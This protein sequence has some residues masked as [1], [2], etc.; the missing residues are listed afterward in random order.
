MTSSDTTEQEQTTS[1][2]KQ[3]IKSKFWSLLQDGLSSVMSDAQQAWSGPDGPDYAMEKILLAKSYRPF[4]WG[5]ATTCLCF[6]TFRVTGSAMFRRLR[7]K[8][9]APPKKPK[10][11]DPKTKQWK[12]YSERLMEER[13]AALDDVASLPT[14]AILSIMLGISITGITLNPSQRKQEFQVAPLLPGRSL[15][16]Q[17]LCTPMTQ[18]YDGASPTIWD[19]SDDANKPDET[20]ET[21]RNF[22][23]HCKR[24]DQVEDTIRRE[25][26][27]IDGT[28]VSIPPP[29]VNHWY[30]KESISSTTQ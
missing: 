22:A 24:R 4:M 12:S 26:G 17:H 3:Q 6:I 25:Q 18:L 11:P 20:L 29:N 13:T 9:S 16:S 14:D 1:S 23:L 7:Q 15:F 21:L 10:P 19:I 5:M 8:M 30:G 28:S 27:L 2:K